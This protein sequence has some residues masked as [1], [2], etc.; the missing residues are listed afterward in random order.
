[1]VEE[2]VQ[3]DPIIAVEL[4]VVLAVTVVAHPREVALVAVALVAALAAVALEVEVPQE[5]GNEY[6]KQY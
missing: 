5:V 3:E 6:S 1:M 4:M 2:E